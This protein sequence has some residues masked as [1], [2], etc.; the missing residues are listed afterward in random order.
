[1]FLKLNRK[2]AASNLFLENEMKF[3]W[4]KYKKLWLFLSL[5]VFVSGFSQDLHFTQ[6]FFAPSNYNPAHIGDFDGDYRVIGNQRR[7]WASVTVPYQTFAGSFDAH[8]VAGVKGLGAMFSFLTDKTG[9][10]HFTYTILNLG[11]S[12]QL[13]STDSSN[14]FTVAIQSGLSNKQFSL[15]DLKYD[16]QYNG[17]F[18]DPGIASIETFNKLSINYL[19]LN[20][21]FKF[22][23]VFGRKSSFHLAGSLY[24]INQPK[25]TFMNN[26]IIRLDRR[27]NLEFGTEHI[28]NNRL[29]ILPL[30]LFSFQG[31]YSEYNIGAMVKYSLVNEMFNKWQVLGG[32]WGRAG[33]AGSLF[34]GL[35]RNNWTFGASYDINLSNLQPASQN[36]GGLELSVIY[37]WKKAPQIPKFKVCP[38]YL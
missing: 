1:L 20:A 38:K 3:N 27:F 13:Q 29:S 24:N 35:I 30:M 7:Q 28:L 33:D 12:Y 21:G 17:F 25:E 14:F 10:S 19:N 36:R 37:I 16:N 15:Q 2:I 5:F 23:H 4:C 8:H 26:A 34:V 9:D 6:F 18:Y 22:K 32:L 31:K 11:L